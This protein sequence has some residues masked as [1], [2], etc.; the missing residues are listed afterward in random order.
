[1]KYTTSARGCE[2]SLTCQLPQE[3]LFV[4]AILESLT[5]I[6]ENHRH[7]VIKLTPKFIVRI[8][9][10]F[11]PGEAAAAGEFRQAFFHH[12][13]QVTT[14]ARINYD[15]AR[16]GHAAIVPL[17]HHLLSRKKA[18]PR[19]KWSFRVWRQAQE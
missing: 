5:A 9:I 16:L 8:D 6:D 13:A 7:L 15:L 18:N 1:M 11:T 19:L 2:T 3:F 17:P 12:F 4:H 10:H 14:F